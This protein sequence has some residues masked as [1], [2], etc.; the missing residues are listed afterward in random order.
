MSCIYQCFEHKCI[1]WVSEW[2][3]RWVG[4]GG[5]R[6]GAG[7]PASQSTMWLL[8]CLFSWQ[9]CTNGGCR[10]STPSTATTD[11]SAPE[12]VP[13][14]RIVSP[15][16]SQLLVS[17]G[18]PRLPNGQC[19]LS[20]LCPNSLCPGDHHTCPMVS[21]YLVHSVPTHCVMGTTTL[22]QYHNIIATLYI[23]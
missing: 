18:P 1:Q 3:S 20:P 14:P 11:E 6:E 23:D 2:V 17:W 13:D 8:G 7:R 22:A 10:L 19:I 4:G 12:D 5:G 15:S 21:V 16:P 9:A